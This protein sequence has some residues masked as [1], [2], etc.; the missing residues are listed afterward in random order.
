VFDAKQSK[1]TCDHLLIIND[2]PVTVHWVVGLTKMPPN[3][4]DQVYIGAITE[5]EQLSFE[6][7]DHVAGKK[8]GALMPW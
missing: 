7:S 1:N 5:A 2:D 4:A 3:F 8:F 6:M